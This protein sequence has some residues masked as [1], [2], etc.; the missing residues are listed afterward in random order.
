MGEQ[1]ATRS[2]SIETRATLAC[3][4]RRRIGSHGAPSTA[5]EVEVEN[6]SR[7]VIEI[8]AAIH[9]L[10]YLNLE[11]TDAAGEVV[12][13]VPYGHI[14]SPR[15]RASVLRLAPGEKYIHNVSLLGTVPAEKLLPGVY[16]VRAVYEYNGLRAVSEPVQVQVPPRTGIPN[17]P[18]LLLV[19]PLA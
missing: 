18:A 11:V 2:A 14:F 7:G 16:T 9:P 12:P 17:E 3:R 15:E 5:G 13:A 6:L 8:E 10:Q 1:T 4:L 19:L